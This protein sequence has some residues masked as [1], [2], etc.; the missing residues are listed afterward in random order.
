MLELSKAM[1]VPLSLSSLPRMC[2]IAQLQPLYP[3]TNDAR[4][5]A[6]RSV[7]VLNAFPNTFGLNM[8]LLSVNIGAYQS[9]RGVRTGGRRG[10]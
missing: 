7:S 1:N 6:K 9:E 10:R 4:N 2:R 3:P 8:A 5:I